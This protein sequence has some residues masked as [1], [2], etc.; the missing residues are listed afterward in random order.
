MTGRWKAWQTTNRFPPLPT[1]P[2][3]SRKDGEIP[4][5]PPPGVAPRESVE[6]QKN[7]SHTPPRPGEVPQGRRDSHIP[8]ARRRP[9]G[10][11]GKPKSGFPHSPATPATATASPSSEPPNQTL[12]RSARKTG[13]RPLAVHPPLPF[14][15]HLALETKVDFSIILRLE[16]ALTAPR[17]VHNRI[18]DFAAQSRNPLPTQRVPRSRLCLECCV[19]AGSEEHTSEL[20]SLRHLVC[21]L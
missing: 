15:Y 3:K 5:F 8:P 2:W 21:R 10:E 14:Q 17:R 6:N 13:E 20:Q 1:A 18:G 9:A 12:G 19:F 11:R 7:G 16:N 4:T